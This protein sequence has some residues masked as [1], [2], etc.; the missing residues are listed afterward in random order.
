M[1][2][3]RL[4]MMEWVIRRLARMRLVIR[5]L[6]MKQQPGRHGVKSRGE[7]KERKERN[8]TGVLNSTDGE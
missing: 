6:V 7:E 4:V 5:K 2:M 1:V 3:M 8:R